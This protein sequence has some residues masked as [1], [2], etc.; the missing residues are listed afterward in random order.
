M[1]IR[2][3]ITAIFTSVLTI[4][5]MLGASNSNA[6][7][8]QKAMKMKDCC[9]MKDGKMMV[10]KNGKN[11]D[12]GQKNDHEKWYCVYAKWRMYHEKWQKNDDEGW[13]LYGY[14]R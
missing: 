2:K 10:M 4:A 12:H 6:Q 8:K 5:L 9:M 3:L 1:K 13:R 11:N 7:A 14:D